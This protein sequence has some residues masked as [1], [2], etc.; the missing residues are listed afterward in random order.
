MHMLTIIRLV[1][2]FLF[3]LSLP[4]A[5]T[6]NIV[7]RSVAIVNGDTIT[8]S[9]VNELGQSF[10]KKISDETPPNRLAE[11]L[12]QA[13]LTVLNKLIEKKLLVQEAKKLG[14][15]VSDQDVENALQRVLASNKATLEEFRKEL[16]SS[17]MSEKQYRDELRE[18]ILSSKLINHEVRTKVVIPESAMIDYYDTHYTTRS[19]GS[20]YHIL[21]I[22]CIWGS[23]AQNG[24]IPTQADAKEKAKKAH[25]LAKDGNNFQ[26]LAKEYSDLPSAVDGGDLGSFQQDEM[27]SYMRNAVTGLKDGDISAIVE[28]DKGYHFFKLVSRGEGK[29]SSRE[30]YESVKEQ[31][32]EKLYQ[33][34]LEQRFKDWM[35]SIKEKAYIKIL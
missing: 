22:G 23:P 26:E 5:A 11:T 29:I 14:I 10:F 21:Q 30:P 15:Q 16:G 17:G 19:D 2:A 6:A 31:I 3:T 28:A 27:V 4:F 12:Q 34:A 7:D 24:A 25:K 20:G 13:R 18:Q 35:T 9:E 33:Q 32:R 1:A 8:L